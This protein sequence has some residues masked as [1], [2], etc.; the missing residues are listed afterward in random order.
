MLSI[1]S[2]VSQPERESSTLI[3]HMDEV[4]ARCKVLQGIFDER[5]RTLSQLQAELHGLWGELD[6]EHD[7]SLESIGEKLTTTRM[8]QFRSAIAA[9]KREKEQR[10]AEVEQLREAAAALWEDLDWEAGTPAAPKEASIDAPSSSSPSD[11]AGEGTPAAAP[12][13]Q[14][15]A[16]EGESVGEGEGQ[17]EAAQPATEEKKEGGEEEE[18]EEGAKSE[19]EGEAKEEESKDSEPAAASGAGS[20][21]EP[22][23]APAQDEEA[24]A[25]AS[26]DSATPSTATA[27][28]KEAIAE[29][30]TAAAE[31]TEA[32]GV[33]PSSIAALHALVTGLE[34]E[35]QERE[36][37]IKGLG[38]SITA[39]WGKLRTPAE[40]QHKF[41]ESHEGVG[42]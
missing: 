24:D 9:S 26:T 16:E 42:D 2:F 7:P 38:E 8:Q 35:K 25:E 4:E 1:A 41:L 40:D 12:A 5:Q 37:V 15:Q 23:V 32:V 10:V 29:V 3:K 28:G 39:L 19:E 34:D 6:A 17:P 33:S 22:E 20:S 14:A 21:E 30:A 27:I 13:T 11:A 31:S 36:G 18:V